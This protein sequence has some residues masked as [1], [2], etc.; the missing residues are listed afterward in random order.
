MI[1]VVPTGEVHDD[2]STTCICRP[3]MKFENGE[4]IIV[5]NAFDGRP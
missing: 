2:E 1:I 5:H 3:S 4:M